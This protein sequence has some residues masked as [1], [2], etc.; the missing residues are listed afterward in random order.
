MQHPVHAGCTRYLT[1]RAPYATCHGP[2]HTVK[3]GHTILLPSSHTNQAAKPCPPEPS[4][5]DLKPSGFL[6]AGQ[7]TKRTSKQHFTMWRQSCV[8][9]VTQHEATTPGRLLP[10]LAA[11]STVTTCRANTRSQQTHK[12]SMKHVYLYARKCRQPVCASRQDSTDV[13]RG[14][15]KTPDQRQA[16]RP[17]MQHPVANAVA[18]AG[19]SAPLPPQQ[20]CLHTHP[21]RWDPAELTCLQDHFIPHRA[22]L[23]SQHRSSTVHPI[24]QHICQNSVQHYAHLAR[25]NTHKMHMH[26]CTTR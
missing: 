1:I 10:L 15:I 19:N 17:T 9:C 7:I 11:V 12:L 2:V 25:T 26:T 23:F 5:R 6:P 24:K 13:S 4:P 20:T 21:S 18:A 8:V 14:V 3:A 22:Q 16:G